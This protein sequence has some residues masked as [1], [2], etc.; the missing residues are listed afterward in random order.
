M[1]T[2]RIK[3]HAKEHANNPVQRP[4][5]RGHAV[6]NDQGSNVSAYMSVY[7]YAQAS[8]ASLQRPL[9]LSANKYYYYYV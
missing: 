8:A 9:N 1:Q 7:V 4:N 5:F 3:L 2:A 6:T